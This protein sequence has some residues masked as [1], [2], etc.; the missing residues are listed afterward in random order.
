[1][2]RPIVGVRAMTSLPN[3]EEAPDRLLL[4]KLLEVELVTT[5][6]FKLDALSVNVKSA[7]AA[8]PKVAYTSSIDFVSNPVNDTVTL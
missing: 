2:V 5:T 7:L 4:I 6:S 8:T 1:M 3:D